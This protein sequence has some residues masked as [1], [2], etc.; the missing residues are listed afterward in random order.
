MHEKYPYEGKYQCLIN[1]TEKAGLNHY[2]DPKAI[3][4]Y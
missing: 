2:D 3:M 1:K 4:N